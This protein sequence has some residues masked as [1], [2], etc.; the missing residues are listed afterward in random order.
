MKTF[1]ETRDN[2]PQEKINAL[3][4]DVLIQNSVL[5][6]PPSFIAF[7][8]SLRIEDRTERAI[9]WSFIDNCVIRLV[10]K[11]VLY[12]DQANSLLEQRPKEL[13][14]LAVVVEE[15]W[16]FAVKAKDDE[17]ET[18]IAWWTSRFIGYLKSV[19]E[20]KTALATV[21]DSMIKATQTK[22][23]Q[24]LLKKAFN[25]TL[26]DSK[27]NQTTTTADDTASNRPASEIPDLKLGEIFGKLPTEDEAHSALH[28]WE[29]EDLEIALDQGHI[30]DLIRYVCSEHEEIRRQA[31][32]S[33]SRF[34]DKLKVCF[35]L[36]SSYNYIFANG[37]V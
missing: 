14:L 22:K 8:E 7:I 23:A 3:L 12:L 32:A 20:D 1:A 36:T 13:S 33:L 26:D 5:A 25:Q 4:R 21:R 35:S 10:K 9:P 6:N 17:A 18:E 28:R 30:G 34:M 37:S 24:S 15:Q 27:K 19:G 31:V 2:K 29:R 16:P 11:P